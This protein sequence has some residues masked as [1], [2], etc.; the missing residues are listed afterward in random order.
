MI[1]T[2]ATFVL[3]LGIGV[4]LGILFGVGINIML[5]LIPSARPFLN[6][7]MKQVRYNSSKFKTIRFYFYIDMLLIFIKKKKDTEFHHT[8]KRI[9]E[10]GTGSFKGFGVGKFNQ[11]LSIMNI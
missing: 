10:L 1:P 7:E 9:R 8:F 5:L 4:E 6:I 2:F 3:C 11:I